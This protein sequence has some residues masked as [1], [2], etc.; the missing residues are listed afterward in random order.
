MKEKFRHKLFVERNKDAE[1]A[2]IDN[3]MQKAAKIKAVLND[4]GKR[5]GDLLDIG[6]SLGIISESLKD[7]FKVTGIDVDA[8]AVGYASDKWSGIDFFIRDAERTDF[9]DGSFDVVIC[10]GIYEHVNDPKNLLKEIHRVLRTG[11]VC[12]FT[13]MNR[14]I[15]VEPH[16]GLPFLSYLS[17]PLADIYLRAKNGKTYDV[18]AFCLPGLRRLVSDFKVFDYT[19]K[20]IMDPEGF[21]ASDVVKPGSLNQKIASWVSKYLYWMVPTYIW[22]LQKE[23][24][25]K[26]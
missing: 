14:L 18:K 25:A 20:V 17:K 8:Q 26:V 16:Y 7:E 9:P 3:R 2:Y 10:A 5:T 15:P 12:Y 1:Q 19:S 22:L 24:N 4:F 23:D 6:C 13:A 21:Y 11:G